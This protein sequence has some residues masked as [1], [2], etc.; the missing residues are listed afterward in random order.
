MSDTENIE[1][2]P[3]TIEELDPQELPGEVRMT[4]TLLQVW[5]EMLSNIEKSAAEK[6]TPQMAMR[7][8]GSWKELKINEVPAYFKMYHEYLL[9]MRAAFSA[10]VETDPKC[11]KKIK[12]DG[13][14]NREH[15]LT[16][17]LQWQLV[18]LQWDIDWDIKAKDAHVRL[19]AMADAS[20]F[21]MGDEG[22]LSYLKFIDFEYSEADRE[23]QIA[24]VEDW[25]DGK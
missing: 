8:S 11:F 19:A 14:K 18:S 5:S 17:I 25:K 13:E 12:D 23:E 7:V 3:D 1:E 24:L 21:F 4:R 20:N 22:L 16:I 9:E 10:E 2:I 6:V 15:Y